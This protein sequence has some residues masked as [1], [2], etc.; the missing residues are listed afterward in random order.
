MYWRVGL[1]AFKHL[2]RGTGKSSRVKAGFLG[3]DHGVGV[4][5]RSFSDK[6]RG[7]GYQ[8]SPYMVDTEV[9]SVAPSQIKVPYLSERLKQEMYG[10][11]KQD[12]ETW[13]VGALSKQYGTSMERTKAVLFLMRRREEFMKEKGFDIIP[14]DWYELYEKFKVLGD[15]AAATSSSSTSPS[16][17]AISEDTAITEEGGEQ[18]GQG[19]HQEASSN[20]AKG[21]IQRLAAEYQMSE[22]KLMVVVAKMKEHTFRQSEVDDYEEQMEKN[23]ERLANV[24]VDTKFR[25]TSSASSTAKSITDDYYPELF[26]DDA[27]F[28][29][30]RVKLIKEIEVETRATA[31][32]ELD[33]RPEF[34]KKDGQGGTHIQTDTEN[35]AGVQVD[36]LSRWKF[37]FKDLSKPKNHPTMMRTRRGNWRQASPL[38]EATRSWLKNP[39]PLD[40]EM[41]RD[42]IQKWRNPDEDEEEAGQLSIKKL[43]RRKAMKEAQDD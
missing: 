33:G 38:E 32:E 29:E 12:S 24:G 23:A 6:G 40:M 7:G 35:R 36:Q 30:A 8:E 34:L 27:A 26:G 9:R 17:P 21:P 3:C 5:V 16:A 22:S 18:E 1:V 31:T 10:K 2:H 41:Y 42:E 25:E 11:H 14:K 15:D 4:V 20:R 28:E 13:S 43:L 37:A 19:D 39:T